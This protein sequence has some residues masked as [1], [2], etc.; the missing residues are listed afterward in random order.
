MPHPLFLVDA[1]TER[2][3]AGNPAGVCL[4]DRPSDARWMQAVAQEMQQAETAFLAR[5]PDDAR[6]GGRW[7]LRWFTPICE[8]DLCGHATLASAHVLWERGLAPPDASLRFATRSGE[9]RATRSTSGAPRIELDFPAEVAHAAPPPS[10]LLPA[11][12]L[13]PRCVPTFVGRNRMDWLVE[14][15]G[16]DGTS[17]GVAE[18]DAAVRALA[19]D[20]ALLAT[21]PARG[22]IV[23]ARAG[24]ATQAD[25]RT[26]GRAF[27]FVSRFFA[28][29]AGVPE[30]PVT[31]SAHCA[32]APHWSARCGRDELS[33]YQASPRGGAVDVKLAGDRVLLRGRAV[34][35]LRGELADAAAPR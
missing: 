33:G 34:T 16:A 20:L 13:P 22:V 18:G 15:G 2:P 21:I 9:L 27:E 7:E 4:L 8:V 35:V 25:A 32:L 10:A 17:G 5:Q 31:G 11:L 3:F 23:T 14:L 19:P 30:D 12:R 1:F 24:V 28:P 29:A 26:S 6:G